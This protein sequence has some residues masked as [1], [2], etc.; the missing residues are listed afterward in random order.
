M[1][2]RNRLAA[3]AL[4][5]SAYNIAASVLAWQ[6]GWPPQFG[7]NPE[8]GQSYASF[9]LSG[10]AIAPPPCSRSSPASP[11]RDDGTPGPTWAWL[12][13]P[14]SDCSS[15]LPRSPSTSP[16]TSSCRCPYYGLGG[17]NLLLGLSLLALT[18]LSWREQRRGQRASAQ[19]TRLAPTRSSRRSS[20]PRGC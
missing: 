4:A 17:V 5:G 20:P 18:G 16:S 6:Q 2:V 11:S 9:L 14:S 1:A 15:P 13:S 3:V 10:A 8:P 19:S 12:R 7:G